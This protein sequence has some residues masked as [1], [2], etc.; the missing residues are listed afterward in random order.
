MWEE[1]YEGQFKDGKRD[2]YVR[3]IY[4]NGSYFIGFWKNKNMHREGKMFNS[5]ETIYKQGKW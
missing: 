5:D 1:I 3:Q 2:G 4:Q